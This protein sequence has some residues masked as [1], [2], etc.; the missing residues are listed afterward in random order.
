MTPLVLCV[1]AGIASL[2][3]TQVVRFVAPKLGAID[4]PASRKLHL[5]PVPRLGGLAVASAMG[6]AFLV[7]SFTDLLPHDHALGV[8]SLWGGI[9]LGGALIFL[10]GLWDDLSPL[11][12]KTK[13][14]VQLVAAGIVIQSGVHLDRIALAGEY[15]FDLGILSI[16]VTVLWI[17]GITNA[18]N[19]IDGLDGL[20]AGLGAIAAATCAVIFLYT[21]AVE[22]ATVL[23][24]LLGALVGFLPFNFYPARI[25]LGDSGSLVLG[26]LLAVMV[27]TSSQRYATAT[28]VAI[29]FLTFGIPILDTLL[30]MVRRMFSGQ[31][32]L[33]KDRAFWHQGL[34]TLQQIFIADR[35]HI[36]HRLLARGLSHRGA[37]LTLYVLAAVLSSLAIVAALAQYRNAPLLLLTVAVA[38]AIGIAK[39][40]YLESGVSRLGTALQRI[41]RP[42][43]DRS[44]FF[45]FTDLLLIALAYWGAYALLGGR[46]SQASDFEWYLN[47]FPAVAL[48]QLCICW[49]AGLYRGLWRAIG[50]GDLM[51][52]AMAVCVGGAMSYSIVMIGQPP[53]GAGSLFIVQA[54]ALGWLMGGL[55]SAYRLVDYSRFFGAVEARPALIYGAG[56]GGRLLLRELRQNAARGLHAIGF[57]DDDCS[58]HG[59]LISG[60]PVLGAGQDLAM[61]LLKKSAH[62]LI[63]SSSAIR[64][65]T[66]ERVLT[67]CRKLGVRVF[68]SDYSFQPLSL[69]CE[70]GMKPMRGLGTEERINDLHRLRQN[71]ASLRKVA[72]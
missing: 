45:G 16:P 22:D 10:C 72:S 37:V 31:G 40:G 50:V 28:A 57:I 70:A 33:A 38:S 66:L 7:A 49:V 39:L 17:V 12:A 21:G 32:R 26:Y 5:R 20:A 51:R 43:F 11:S 71:I 69:E 18:F 25:F 61:L 67:D 14:L 44:F 56:L 23:C 53:E 1:V 68:R 59:R 29:P 8:P 9:A 13:L 30:S 46:G 62:V 24:V 4:Q 3:L 55:R 6:V 60:I 19:L 54:L 15:A 36:H 64:G 27:I 63:V 65:E 34:L 42:Q 41:D 48:I 2:C 58:L 47:M 35:D 52:V